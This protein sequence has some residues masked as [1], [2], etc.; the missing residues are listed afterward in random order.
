M[1]S[2]YLRLTENTI[3]HALDNQRLEA[4]GK[5]TFSF[6]ERVHKGFHE[7]VVGAVKGIASQ[8]CLLG[9]IWASTTVSFDNQDDAKVDQFYNNDIFIVLTAPIIEEVFF[10]GI[11]Q[12][13][14]HGLQVLSQKI[15]PARMQNNRIFKWLTSPSARV[16]VPNSLFAGVHLLN[17]GGYL[18]SGGA[19][20]QA[21]KIFI[22]PVESILFETTKKPSSSVSSFFENGVLAMVAPMTCHIA[23]NLFAVDP[24]AA[25]LSLYALAKLKAK[26][27]EKPQIDPLKDIP[28]GLRFS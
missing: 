24:L 21:G 2:L 13:G 20:M 12:N 26:P 19:L 22:Y 9:L 14:A 23:N 5:K 6:A 11:L 8:L 3:F 7:G 27:Q 15:L 1:S 25:L 28:K 18:S 16:L 4:N 10:R 17:G